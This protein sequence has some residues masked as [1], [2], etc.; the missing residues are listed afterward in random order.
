MAWP[1][2]LSHLNKLLRAASSTRLVAALALAAAGM[3]HLS[4]APLAHEIGTTSVTATVTGK[5]YTV[6][7]VAEAPSL[8]ARLEASADQAR[9]PRLTPEQYEARFRSLQEELL[10]RLTLRFDGQQVEPRVERVDIEAA[11]ASLPAEA[12]LESERVRVRLA[13]DVPQGARTIS[14]AFGLAYATYPLTVKQ[15][16]AREAITEWL[17][18]D[19]QSSPIMIQVSQAG[20]PLRVA[21]TYVAIAL[22]GLSLLV[23]RLI[24]A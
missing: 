6:E 2:E 22:I 18:G 13:G 4:E 16:D 14:W 1:S 19:R 11:A 8:L 7:L 10:E 24:Q 21:A 20:S 23:Q 15:A 17:E 5:R 12:S 9:S 3:A